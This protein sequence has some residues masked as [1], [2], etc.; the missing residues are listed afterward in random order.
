MIKYIKYS[1]KL[2]TTTARYSL[3]LQK[4]SDLPGHCRLGVGVHVQV[5]RARH[6]EVRQ[7]AL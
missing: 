1:T 4:V 5:V 2:Y 3:R 6:S 7:Y